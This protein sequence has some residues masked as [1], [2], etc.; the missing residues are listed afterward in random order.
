M[1][2]AEFALVTITSVIAVMNSTSTVA[3]YLALTE[4][5]GLEERGKIIAKSMKISFLVLAC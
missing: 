5:M 3:V 4:N 2:P 1:G